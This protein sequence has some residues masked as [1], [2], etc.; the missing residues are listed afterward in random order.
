MRRSYEVEGEGLGARGLEAY[1]ARCVARRL[2]LSGRA[3][4]VKQPLGLYGPEDA[5][6]VTL[7][8]GRRSVNN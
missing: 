4:V 8:F 7:D 6:P 1:R 5:P 3:V 2:G